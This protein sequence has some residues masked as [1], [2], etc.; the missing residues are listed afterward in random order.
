MKGGTYVHGKAKDVG[1]AVGTRKGA[2]ADSSPE[3]TAMLRRVGLNDV[4]VMDFIKQNLIGGVDD[5]TPMRLVPFL[6]FAKHA[7]EDG[8][9]S[10][11]RS[12]DGKTV[13]LSEVPED[14]NIVFISHRWLRPWRSQRECEAAGHPW[15]GHAHP[16]DA[17]GTKHGLICDGL[18]GLA[19]RKLWH[20]SMASVFLWI[21]F[22]GVEQD[23][24]DLLP[25]ACAS[26]GGYIAM[27]DAIL[28]PS[29]APPDAGGARSFESIPCSYS[30][31]GW[32]Q[33]EALA[34]YAVSVLG[35]KEA[36]EIWVTAGGGGAFL[37]RFDYVFR[38][39]PST[40]NLFSE[41]DREFILGHEGTYVKALE[42]AVAR[43][44]HIAKH[45]DW[46]NCVAFDPR[47]E[48]QQLVVSGG[49]DGAIK[50]VSAET[51]TTVWSVKT[52]G[53]VK[54]VAFSE[55]GGL[56]A[57]GVLT[58][59]L[60]LWDVRGACPVLVCSA[61]R[62]SSPI[63][64]VAFSADG[65][66]LASASADT[67]V[68][69]SNGRTMD[70]LGVLRGHRD[71]VSAVA[72]SPD[73]LLLASACYDGQVMLWDP[74][75]LKQAGRAVAA[76]GDG[77]HC[78]AFSPDGALLASGGEDGS[79]HV[80][81]VRDKE[82]KGVIK[83]HISRVYSVAFSPD[84]TAL[85]S[86]SLDGSVRVWNHSA[87]KELGVL[88]GHRGLVLSVAFS[89]DSGSIA[90]GGS[91]GAVMVWDPK[92]L[93]DAA[94]AE[95]HAGPVRFVDLSPDGSLL[96]TAGLDGRVKVW[97]PRTMRERSSL[98]VCAPHRSGHQAGDS[99]ACLAISHNN[100]YLAVGTAQGAIHVWNLRSGEAKRSILGHSRAIKGCLCFKGGEYK[101]SSACP[102]RRHA[103]EVG[104]LAF[105]SDGASLI[106]AGADATV[107]VW[108]LNELLGLG[109]MEG[110]Q[111]KFAASPTA[112]R[113]ARFR[114][115]DQ[116]A[117]AEA[118]RPKSTLQCNFYSGDGRLCVVLSDDESFLACANS[119]DVKVWDWPTLKE[120]DKVKGRDG[121]WADP[122]LEQ[123]QQARR[124]HLRLFREQSSLRYTS[125]A[126]SNRQC[127]CW[128]KDPRTGLRTHA[129]TPECPLMSASDGA[130]TAA[131]A[132]FSVSANE[133]LVLI[134][135][136]P[137]FDEGVI[138][139]GARSFRAPSK[140][141][142]IACRPPFVFA[143][144]R[145]G[146]VL[147]LEAPIL[148]HASASTMAE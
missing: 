57:A 90:S 52:L 41:L 17:A 135:E 88:R 1:A 10:I 5:R 116:P 2:D 120:L 6:A 67:T 70:P 54:C 137:L 122:R 131:C 145:E 11:P 75:R 121:S 71:I 49:K 104:S 111:P 102:L 129:P 32:T 132:P 114:S 148:S 77:A 113:A 128:S 109:S 123:R 55:D 147:C 21:D 97:D 27:C 81:N 72:F 86:G 144:C 119:R 100:S 117:H 7:G 63:Y 103:G 62:H 51:G 92:A 105:P 29:P 4:E 45:R 16:D 89:A 64:A 96:A 82:D 74:S 48:R 134:H 69:L 98:A 47:D 85:A 99:I 125:H 24:L 33:L 115:L 50:L 130:L 39:L 93:Q 133:D 142:C 80:F 59:V 140:V 18:V 136:G 124:E 19:K 84:G 110:R 87:M 78:V 138:N 106:S 76:H 65:S 126:D 37:E 139:R 53:D 40:G 141:E 107:R 91:D 66:L 108:N 127:K 14:A 73:G 31:R 30:D 8:R 43:M 143:G 22:A 79:V 9:G 58:G 56:M 26:L 112:S 12:S 38:D 146:K 15:A 101:E 68:R 23:S 20:P 46:V 118:P 61:Q 34:M 83:A 13:L 25:A 35:Q 3:R 44:G 42:E 28:I 95:A 94:K 36:P 60:K